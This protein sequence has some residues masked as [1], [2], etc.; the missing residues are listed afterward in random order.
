[1]SV[2]AARSSAVKVDWGKIVSSLGL[3][4]ATVSSLQAFRKRHEEAKKNAY[5]LQNQP[6]EVDF[7]HYRKV[8]KNQKVVDEI[9]QHF[10]SFKPVTY[11]VSKQ[12]KTIDAFEAKA[13][14][15]AKTTEGKVNQ[16]IGDLQKTLENIESARPFDQLSVDDVFKA[17][18]DLEKKIEEMV[19]KGRWSVPGYNEKFGS[20]VLM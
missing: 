14:E 15:D 19:K 18:P 4:G 12:L 7:S 2:A 9:E 16:E 10:K 3:T 20:V 13:L 1:M 8:L 17:R 6:T 5:E 11:D